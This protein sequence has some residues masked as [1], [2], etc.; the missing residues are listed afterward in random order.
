MFY[1][2]NDCDSSI[3]DSA[4][5]PSIIVTHPCPACY[6]GSYLTNEGEKLACMRCPA[7][8]YSLG[9]DLRIDGLLHEWSESNKF[10]RKFKS[11]CKIVDK[12]TFH[13]KEISCNPWILSGTYLL[14]GYSTEPDT[15][16]YNE[17]T[18]RVN[19]GRSGTVIKL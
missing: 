3:E 4:K 12:N 10:W 2:K 19:L 8:T 9:G 13:N 17:L 18:L 7:N 15:Y 14:S 11:S 5:L 1:Y 6:K 16:F